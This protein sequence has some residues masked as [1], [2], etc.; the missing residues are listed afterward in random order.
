MTVKTAGSVWSGVRI[1]NA[2]L[3][4]T[5]PI[6]PMDDRARQL[7]W[8]VWPRVGG[9]TLKTQ[10][11]PLST[12]EKLIGFSGVNEVDATQQAKTFFPDKKC[13]L[14]ALDSANPLPGIPACWEAL[15]AIVIDTA[16][17]QAVGEQKFSSL[18]GSGLFF[19]VHR[20]TD[21][22]SILFKAWPWTLDGRWQTLRYTPAGPL[23]SNYSEEYY[24]PAANM[25]PGWPRSTRTGMLL[26]LGTL[27]L[28]F[29]LL[30]IWR[31]R[32]VIIYVAMIAGFSLACFHQWGTFHHATLIHSGKIRYQSAGITQDDDWAFLTCHQ[33]TFSTIRWNDTLR[34]MYGSPSHFDKTSARLNCSSDGKP[35][36]I[37]F[38]VDATTKMAVFSRRCGPR[39]PLVLPA[40]SPNPPGLETLLKSN[41]LK[42]GDTIVGEFPPTPLL[43]EPNGKVSQW[44]GIAIRRD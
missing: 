11:R 39:A 14:I 2:R 17:L 43:N 9:N 37:Q 35:E 8:Y 23:A 12:N 20:S 16:S 28:L 40:P 19:A 36:H 41:Y 31:P 22:P 3:N 38:M 1:D 44:P 4:V 32:G 7:E 21:D 29:L 34:L 18:V 30:A 24:S 42:P 5:V 6:L 27:S 25:Y 33:Q 10:L 13:I 26:F 15:D